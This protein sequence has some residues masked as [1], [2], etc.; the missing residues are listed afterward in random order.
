MDTALPADMPVL[1]APRFAFDNSYARLPEAFHV[2]LPPIPV[3]DAK[4][5]RLNHP[6]AERLGLDPAELASAEGVAVLSGSALAPGS[7]PLTQAY[8]GHQ[9]GHFNPKL[10]DGRAHLL[11]EVVA[12]DGARFDIQLKGSGRTPWSRG[13]DGRAA[14]GPMLREYIVSEALHAFG[15]PTTRSLAVV[16]TGEW[17]MREAPL[18]GAVL[19]RVASSHLRV[20]TFQ[21]FAARSDRDSLQR[22]LDYAIARHDPAAATAA[23]P[24]L[25][26]LHGVIARQA[27]LIT[28]W[29]LVGFVHG[30]MNTDNMAVS[31]ESIDFGPCAFME[32]YDPAMVLSSIDHQ[33]RYAYGNQP[34]IGQWNATRLAE[35][36]LPLLAAE[37]AAA[38]E[39][40][41]D[42]LGAFSPRFG[43]AYGAGLLRK[44]GLIV[45]RAGDSALVQDLLERMAAQGADFTLTFRHLAEAAAGD[46]APARALFADPAAFDAWAAG[47]RARLAAEAPGAAARIEAANPLYIPRNH[48]VEEALAAA[49]EHEDYRPFETLLDVLARPFVEQP[50]R[51]RYALPATATERVTATFCGT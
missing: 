15:I 1:A 8:A 49:T 28:Q 5:V 37:E 6:L 25:A 29:L 32:A 2:R 34:R 23:N 40:A 43:E 10:G 4:L 30:V 9:F 13:G 41:K 42:A 19:T 48:L 22:L 33:G 31:G 17:V 21:Y 45:P 44:I 18:P 24:A 16:T 14:I 39:L 20:G 3:K 38:I 27:A 46:D 47:W 7:E 51:A 36:L 11:G 26:F 12:P 50:G 35:A